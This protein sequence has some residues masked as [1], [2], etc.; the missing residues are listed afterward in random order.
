[1][2]KKIDWASKIGE[3]YGTRIITG[4]D[5]NPAMDYRK[6]RVS[7]LCTTCGMERNVLY[8]F[9]RTRG[10][11]WCATK[12]RPFSAKENLIG[13]RFGKLIVT[14]FN[15]FS[16]YKKQNNATWR[17]VCDCGNVKIVMDSNLKRGVTQSC[18]CL[19]KQALAENATTHGE[20]HTVFYKV[21]AMHLSRSFL[22]ENYMRWSSYE[23]FK[24]HTYQSFLGVCGG[25]EPKNVKKCPRLIPKNEKEPLGKDNFIWLHPST[26]GRK[27]VKMPGGQFLSFQDMAKIAGI[28]R[29]QVYNRMKAGYSASDILRPNMFG[30]DAKKLKSKMMQSLRPSDSVKMRGPKYRKSRTRYVTSFEECQKNIQKETTE[31]EEP[32]E[33]T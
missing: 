29:Q 33:K 15:G 16:R 24:N 22:Y 10:C 1:M 2:P 25:N 6:Q 30:E 27:L 26:K 5:A 20:S 9:F 32:K 8:I 31:P 23:E 12:K 28:S 3:K 17:V 19:Q 21:W 7:T 14:E 13:R 18:G 11:F 4:I